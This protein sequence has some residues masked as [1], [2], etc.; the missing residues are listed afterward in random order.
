MEI[1]RSFFR[2]FI[3]CI[4]LMS[5]LALSYSPLALGSMDDE[6]VQE[7]L[8]RLENKFEHINSIKVHFYQTIL[9]KGQKE[10][11]RAR[12]TAWFKRPHSMRWEYEAPERQLIIV[13]GERV[14]LWEQGPNQV[15]VYKRKRFIPG[16]LGNIFFPSASLIEKNFFVEREKSTADTILLELTPKGELSGMRKIHVRFHR[17]NMMISALE[18]EDSLGTKTVIR[19]E[20]AEVNPDT[21]EEL[22]VFKPPEGA[23][24]YYQD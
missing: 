7:V 21:P 22:F 17:S 1:L 12:G 18:F 14:F 20:D 10:P 3:N 4:V 9:R 16:E 19:F 15:M 23:K 5:F 24:I 11:F 2:A 8:K 6:G 13:N